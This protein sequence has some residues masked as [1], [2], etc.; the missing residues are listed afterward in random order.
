MTRIKR[1]RMT[2]SEVEEQYVKERNGGGLSRMASG[3]SKKSIRNHSRSLSNNSI[4]TPVESS[5]M[6]PLQSISLT[7]ASSRPRPMSV[8]S[9]SER[10]SEED[11]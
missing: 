11:G 4:I 6:A 7:S 10:I 8:A 9:I 2:P 3:V 5:D 1:T